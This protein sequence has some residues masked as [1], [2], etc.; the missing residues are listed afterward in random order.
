MNVVQIGKRNR[1]IYLDLFS[2][3]YDPPT[4]KRVRPLANRYAFCNEMLRMAK[5][6]T[7]TNTSLP[8]FQRKLLRASQLPI[9]AQACLIDKQDV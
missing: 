6:A 8:A 3:L 7:S 1:L 9:F 2:L 5:A 4:V